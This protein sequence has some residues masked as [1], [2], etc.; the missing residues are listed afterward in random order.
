MLLKSWKSLHSIQKIPQSPKIQ[1]NGK[2][3]L[4]PPPPK[5][6]VNHYFLL[7]LGQYSVNTTFYLI[8]CTIKRESKTIL[9]TLNFFVLADAQEV[10]NFINLM[11]ISDFLREKNCLSVKYFNETFLSWIGNNIL[12]FWIKY[13]IFFKYLY[14]VF[15]LLVLRI[16]IFLYI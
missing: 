12:Q 13:K 3:K 11:C 14:K 10:S 8:L 2:I 16:N 4:M 1:K 7:D 5:K 15:T 9:M 6:N